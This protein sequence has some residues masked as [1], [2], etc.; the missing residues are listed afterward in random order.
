[1]RSFYDREFEEFLFRPFHEAEQRRAF[2]EKW[3]AVVTPKMRDFV[4]ES[5]GVWEIAN[6]PNQAF[7]W[8]LR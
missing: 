7:F 2:L 6:E 8:P 5:A 3:W 1:M 4:H